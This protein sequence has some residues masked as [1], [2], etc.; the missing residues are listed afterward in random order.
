MIT[1]L[2]YT[3]ALLFLIVEIDIMQNPQKAVDRSIRINAATASI[4]GSD[5]TYTTI[6][7]FYWIWTLAGLATIQ[8]PAFVALILLAMITK[9]RKVLRMIDASI[10]ALLVLF[11]YINHFHLKLNMVQL[12][13]AF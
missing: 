6:Q 5:A 1:Y 13:S 12:F 3:A 8:W 9:H 4:T 2:F 11:I 7:M 10:S